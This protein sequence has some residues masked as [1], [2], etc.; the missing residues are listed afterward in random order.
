[1]RRREF[2]GVLGGAAATWPLGV[3]A[4]TLPVIGSLSGVVP[5]AFA[6]ELDVF[7]QSLSAMGYVPGQNVHIEYRWAEGHYDWLPKLAADLVAQ[8]VAVIFASGTI[9]SAQVAKAATATIPIVFLN[10]G[11]PIADG[12]VASI[13]RPEGNITGVTFFS[14]VLWAKRFGLLLEIAPAASTIAVLINPR[15]ARAASDTKNVQDTARSVGKQVVILHA[16]TEHEVGTAFETLKQ[17]GA[18]A[19]FV[20]ADAFMN[21]RR[22]QLAT[23]SAQY[24]VPTIYPWR[25]AVL[26][27][28]LISYG[29]KISDAFHQA[30]IYVGANPQGRKA[31]RPAGSAAQ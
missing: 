21:G 23:L 31:R 4:Q 7:R 28:G 3:H 1:M 17:E 13:N 18:G 15:N 11:D 19:L 12:L 24:A 10:G 27:G 20:A 2:L 9:T 5:S 25:E 8:R 26:A 22:Q 30:G 16:S 14:N 29:A 6:K